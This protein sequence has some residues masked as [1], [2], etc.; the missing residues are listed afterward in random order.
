MSRK[1]IINRVVIRTARTVNLVNRVVNIPIPH[2]IVILQYD[3]SIPYIYIY[4]LSTS[5]GRSCGF[6]RLIVEERVCVLLSLDRKIKQSNN[7]ADMP[8]DI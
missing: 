6:S 3:F 5:S 1:L 4:I 7:I 2:S 8:I